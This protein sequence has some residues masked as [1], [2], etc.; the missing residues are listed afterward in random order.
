MTAIACAAVCDPSSTAWARLG[1]RPDNTAA[2]YL[3]VDTGAQATAPELVDDRRVQCV[4]YVARLVAVQR[5]LDERLRVQRDEHEHVL[6]AL[7]VRRDERREDRVQH[8]AWRVAGRR[9][10]LR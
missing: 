5:G 3:R 1:T 2:S 7:G 4:G 9:D 8:L 10:T 6:A